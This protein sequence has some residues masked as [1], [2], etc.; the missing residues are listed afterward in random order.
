MGAAVVDSLD[1]FYAS[2]KHSWE[3]DVEGRV[4]AAAQGVPL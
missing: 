3:G 4:S 1:C 2:V